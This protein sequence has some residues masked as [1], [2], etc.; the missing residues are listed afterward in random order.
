MKGNK[1]GACYCIPNSEELG[2]RLVGSVNVVAF[3]L[4]AVFFFSF[5]FIL[6]PLEHQRVKPSEGTAVRA[7]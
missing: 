5:G 7:V 3:D 6:R 1:L 2:G 4:G